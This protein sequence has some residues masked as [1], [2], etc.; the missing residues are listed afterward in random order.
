MLEQIKAVIFDMDGTLMDSMWLWEDID[1]EY[2][3]RYG[4]SVPPGLQNEIAGMSF[5]ET[6]G[7]FKERF[8]IP[9]SIEAIKNDWNAMAWEKYNTE[10]F[11]KPGCLEFLNYL[12][13]SHIKTGIATSNSRELTELVLDRQQIRNH[14]DSIRTS[15]EVKR[16]KPFPDIYELVAS[17]LGVRPEECLVFEDVIPGIQ[18]G[19]TAGMNVCAVY[20]PFSAKEDQQKRELADYYINNFYNIEEAW[21]EQTL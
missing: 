5:T 17:D 4:I 12:K 19:K 10:V 18:A 7:Y 9:A 14:M 21:R 13:R 2:L 6:A 16:G 20:D 3:G 11:L 15:C 1:I 8:Q